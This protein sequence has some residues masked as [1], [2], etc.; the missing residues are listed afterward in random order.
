VASLWKVSDQMTAEL[1]S[2]FYRHLRDGDAKDEALRR[3][4]LDLLHGPLTLPDRAGRGREERADGSA[5]F[6]W[7]AFQL[8]GD[9]L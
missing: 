6:F 8:S 1:M 2:R 3:A 9:W 5:P 7:A 4:Q